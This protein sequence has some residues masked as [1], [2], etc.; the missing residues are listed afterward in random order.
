MDFA[1]GR[2]IVGI[3]MG[4]AR[5]RFHLRQPYT[6]MSA[7]PDAS[8]TGDQLFA[9]RRDWGSGIRGAHFFEHGF[10]GRRTA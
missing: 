1:G 8:S 5:S 4:A 6:T 10:S 7:R 3:L 2:I 9:A